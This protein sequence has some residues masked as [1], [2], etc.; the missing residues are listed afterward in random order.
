M[1]F[2][3]CFYWCT[4]TICG[5]TYFLRRIGCPN[6]YEIITYFETTDSDMNHFLQHQINDISNGISDIQVAF[7]GSIFHITKDPHRLYKNNELFHCFG[8]RW[9]VRMKVLF[10]NKVLVEFDENQF[11]IYGQDGIL[12]HVFSLLGAIYLT[13]FENGDLLFLTMK[14]TY[15]APTMVK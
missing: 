15:N 10:H 12:Q 13:E 7:D 9:V 11:E 6:N 14:I 5:D 8:N 3:I 2:S 1:D 4:S